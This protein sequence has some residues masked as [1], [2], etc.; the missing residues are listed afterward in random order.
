MLVWV[1]FDVLNELDD[2]FTHQ[3]R[4]IDSILVADG[5]HV[6][7]EGQ[8]HS[9]ASLVRVFDH[10]HFLSS[11][12]ILVITRFTVSRILSSLGLLD[13]VLF[14]SPNKVLSLEFSWSFVIGYS[15]V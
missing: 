7:L 2:C 12:W 10:R 1:S 5:G 15:P 9:Q 14:L 3:V 8:R 11:F 13:G 4:F 6:F